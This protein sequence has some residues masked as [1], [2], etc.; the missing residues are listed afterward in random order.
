[1][2]GVFYST[3]YKP[4]FS[5]NDSENV[6]FV[7]VHGYGPRERGLE[8]LMPQAAFY[9]G[10][11]KTSIPKIPPSPRYKPKYVTP[12]D[13]SEGE[14]NGENEKLMESLL[15]SEN[16]EE[17]DVDDDSTD[18]DDDGILSEQNY[19]VSQIITDANL[20]KQIQNKKR[21]FSSFAT[22]LIDKYENSVSIPPLIL[23]IGVELPD[24]VPDLDDQKA[25]G[26][27]LS[28]LSYRIQ[29]RKYF[30]EEIFPRL[31]EFQPDF[32]FISA[33]F[34]AHKKDTINGGYMALVEEDFEWVTQCLVNI[35]NSCCNGRIVSV[36]EGGYQLGGEYCS[37]F[38]QSAK[39]HVRSLAQGTR[40][41]APFSISESQG[42]T[43]YELQHLNSLKELRQAQIQRNEQ[44]KLALAFQRQQE[45][46][47]R[48]VEQQDIQNINQNDD[49]ISTGATKANE[50][51]NEDKLIKK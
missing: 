6:L 11:G 48:S 49:S 25:G 26:K 20:C 27:M 3:K 24:A 19:S 9:P 40:S 7:S 14:K 12:I 43:F 21:I 13:I 50:I 17:D 23:D 51:S 8:S 36:L 28:E 39:A 5:E 46:E 18:T 15:Q 47:S 44:R 34:D 10:S 32:I 16:E 29:W 33:G 2:F 41:R 35:A 38:A 30:R 22:N 1:M 42:E 31:I 37:A 45:Y 4:W